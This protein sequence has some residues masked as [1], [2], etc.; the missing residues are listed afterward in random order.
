MEDE[1]K[2][3]F[4]RDIN[5][6][7]DKAIEASENYLHL[8]AIFN[9][10]QIISVNCNHQLL[11]DILLSAKIVVDYIAEKSII[12]SNYGRSFNIKRWFVKSDCSIFCTVK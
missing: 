7:T 2:D 3:V 4:N 10:A 8:E 11:L 5:L 1:L 12:F 9:S 6:V